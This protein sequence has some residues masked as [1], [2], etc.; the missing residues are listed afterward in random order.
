M[1]NEEYEAIQL[2]YKD[3]TV[4]TLKHGC[5]VEVEP[6]DDEERVGIKILFPNN[7]EKEAV[8]TILKVLFQLGAT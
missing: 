1:D 2:V 6:S 8:E 7:L 4:E 5:I 3:G